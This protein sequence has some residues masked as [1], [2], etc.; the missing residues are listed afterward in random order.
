MFA[1]NGIIIIFTLLITLMA[2]I[3]PLPL[4][5]D[6]FRPDWVLIVLI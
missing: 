6:A 4:S 2:T 5:V 3:M 1:H